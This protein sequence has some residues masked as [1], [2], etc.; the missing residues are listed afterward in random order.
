[1]KKPIPINIDCGENFGNYNQYNEEV[2]LANADLINVACGFHAGDFTNIISTLE[3][4]TERGIKIGAHPSYPDLQGF[5]RRYM[6]MTEKEIYDLTTFQISTIY[7]LC[8]KYKT[9]LNHVKAH[10]ALYHTVSHGKLGEAFLKAIIDFDKLITILA[11]S[12]SELYRLCISHGVS[13]MQ[14]AFADRKYDKSM[15]LVSRNV[16]GSVYHSAEPMI[17]QYQ[18]ICEGYVIDESNEIRNIQADTIC[19]HGDNKSL[20]LFFESIKNE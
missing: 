4:A 18:T 5:G 7:G 19:I 13:C 10:G 8:T 16:E 12:G 6:S 1:M 3:K 11:P 2:I 17:K 20:E 15:Q 14:E 9:R